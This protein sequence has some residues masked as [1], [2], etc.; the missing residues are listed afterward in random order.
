MRPLSR[1]LKIE[2]QKLGQKWRLQERREKELIMPREP[3]P[4]KCKRLMRRIKEL[5][6]KLRQLRK[7]SKKPRLFL[8]RKMQR[9]RE[10]EK[11]LLQI[12]RNRKLKPKREKLRP[13]HSVKRIKRPLL[14]LRLKER[15]PLP[16]L[17]LLL[18]R[19]MSFNLPLERRETNKW[20]LSTKRRWRQ[21]KPH[22]RSFSRMFGSLVQPVLQRSRFQ[23]LHSGKPITSFK[24]GSKI[25]WLLKSLMLST[26]LESIDLLPFIQRPTTQSID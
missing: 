6:L 12:L 7:R 23:L 24:S 8:R 15:P 20:L 22:S 21:R 14:R 25:R 17:E 19:L 26:S 1:L 5:K 13:K 10:L 18:R 4:S 9:P 2:Q 16:L 11:K 3:L